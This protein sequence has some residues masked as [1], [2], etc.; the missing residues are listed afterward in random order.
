MKT[1]LCDSVPP[2]MYPPTVNL[3]ANNVNP[4][5]IYVTWP[6]ITD[7]SLSGRDC[8]NYYGLEWDQGI[9]VWTNLTNPSMGLTNSFNVTTE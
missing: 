2:M 7:C 9:G 6:S 8:P 5:W 4:T 3:A 1:V